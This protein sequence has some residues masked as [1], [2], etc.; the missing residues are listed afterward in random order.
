[1]Y[2]KVDSHA[3]DTA[4]VHSCLHDTGF[5]ALRVQSLDKVKKALVLVEEEL[6]DPDLF[7]DFFE[8]AFKFCLTVA[9]D[10]HQTNVLRIL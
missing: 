8:F 2:G 4:H 7:L 5:H 6:R 10:P 1:M 3:Q 9:S